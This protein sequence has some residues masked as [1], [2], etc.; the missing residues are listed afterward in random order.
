VKRAVVDTCR[1]IPYDGRPPAGSLLLECGHEIDIPDYSNTYFVR[2]D[3]VR[4]FH[5]HH[6]HNMQKAEALE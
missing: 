2:L 1:Q 5:C 3:R 6:C 4:R